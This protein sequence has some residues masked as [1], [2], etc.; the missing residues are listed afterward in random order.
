[1]S[2]L[3]KNTLIYTIGNVLTALSAFLLLPVYTKYMSV[4]DFGISN[5][6]QTFSAILLVIFSFALD[7]SLSR[8]YYDYTE[9]KEKRDFLGTIF[10]S[11]LTTGIIFTIISLFAKNLVNQLFPNIPFY[12][13]FTYSILYTFLFLIIN[14]AQTI[15]QVKQNSKQFLF[16]SLTMVIIT[17][18]CNLILV[19]KYNLGA[20]G[21]VKGMMIGATIMIPLILVYIHKSINY[22]FKVSKLKIA[23]V[24]SLPVLPSLL[25]AW[26]L[27]LSDRIFINNFFSSSDVGIYSLGYRIA[28]IIVFISAALFM[29]YNPLFFEIANNKDLSDEVK[30]EKLRKINAGIILIIGIIGL[31]LLAGSDIILKLFFKR[32]YLF[33]YTYISIFGISFIIGQIAAFF[34][35]MVY[36]NKKTQH[37]AIIIIICACLNILLNYYLIPSYGVY[38]AAINNLI[39]TIVNVVCMYFL[40]KRNFFISTDWKVI[41]IIITT[42]LI[43]YLENKILMDYDFSIT[44]PLKIITILLIL[45]IFKNPI[46]KTLK[47]IKNK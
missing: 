36:Q 18:C 31:C 15:A 17:A 25:S 28:S 12:P 33:A 40:A 39:C 7:R 16:I 26:I 23:L 44:I 35:L 3:L 19:V 21:Y 45:F 47:T 32:E 38:F 10:F 43:V 27:N 42:Y 6:M 29:A 20:I 9:E 11:L 4:D 14:F 13:Y 34:N 22:T 41:S 5:S 37:V 46:L 1:M 24:Y 8:I 30:K 2:K